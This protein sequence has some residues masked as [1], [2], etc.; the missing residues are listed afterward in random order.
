MFVLGHIPEITTLGKVVSPLGVAKRNWCATGDSPD[1][2]F[3]LYLP[4]ATQVSQLFRPLRN[5]LLETL[6]T[7]IMGAGAWAEP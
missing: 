1:G 3:T 5:T 2:F 6:N 7:L 4:K